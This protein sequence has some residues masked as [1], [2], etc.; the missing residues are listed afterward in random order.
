MI[1]IRVKDWYD[2]N[3]YNAHLLHEAEAREWLWD[4][5]RF[6]LE[7]HGNRHMNPFISVEAFEEFE[8]QR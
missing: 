4:F 3:T 5:T 8:P 2:G 6:I 7:L 1:Y